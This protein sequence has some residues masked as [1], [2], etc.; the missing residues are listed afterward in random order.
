MPSLPAAPGQHVARRVFDILHRSC[1][2][3]WS[4]LMGTHVA[5][6]CAFSDGTS[7]GSRQDLGAAWPKEEVPERKDVV[8]M[9]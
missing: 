9:R 3:R 6:R 4:I 7:N 8:Q 1:R 5:Q 2:E